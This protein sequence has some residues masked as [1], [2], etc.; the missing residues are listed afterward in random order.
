[1]NGKKHIFKISFTN[2][3]MPLSHRVSKSFHCPESKGNASFLAQPLV[4][5][6]T[7]SVIKYVGYCQ[8]G[9]RFLLYG[10]IFQE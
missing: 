1:M 6:L 4:I 10:N 3:K 5:L 2:K 9:K 8:S 7:A